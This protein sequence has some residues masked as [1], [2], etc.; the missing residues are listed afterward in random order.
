MWVK[1]ALPLDRDELEEICPSNN[2]LLFDG[3][4]VPVLA[5]RGN[6]STTTMWSDGNKFALN[7]K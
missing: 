7:N 1:K 2:V 6:S 4:N 3:G 5:I